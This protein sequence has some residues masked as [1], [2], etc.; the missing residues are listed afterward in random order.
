MLV[1]PQVGSQPATNTRMNI[2]SVIARCLYTIGSGV[3]VVC[4]TSLKFFENC[5]CTCACACACA[6]LCCAHARYSNEHSD[7][8]SEVKHLPPPQNVESPVAVVREMPVQ[9][10]KP[11]PSKTVRWTATGLEVPHSLFLSLSRARSNSV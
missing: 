8:K 10:S 4:R 7:L 5:P 1:A 2:N 9:P 11:A 6:C 3:C